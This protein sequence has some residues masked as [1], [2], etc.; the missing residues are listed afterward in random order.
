MVPYTH[1][2]RDWCPRVRADQAD[3]EG[4]TETSR[5]KWSDRVAGEVK[6]VWTRARDGNDQ[7]SILRI[8]CFRSF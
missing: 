1:L 7:E 5:Q 8:I 4:W 6:H 3:A 2:G